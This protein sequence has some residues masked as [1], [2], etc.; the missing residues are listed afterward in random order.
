MCVVR[1]F[2]AIAAV[3]GVLLGSMSPS[4]AADAETVVFDAT[5]YVIQAGR[6]SRFAVFQN[7]LQTALARCGSQ[8]RVFA[9]GAAP[10]GKFDE[11]TRAAIR[12][13]VECTPDNPHLRGG[14]A[15]QGVLTLGVWRAIMGDGPPP[16]V[17]E[18]ARALV[19]SF[20]ATDF[21]DA[22]LWNLCQDGTRAR[23]GPSN[24]NRAA[25]QCFNES[26]P[27]SF[28]TWGPRGATAG[29]GREI[30]HVL[31]M[32]AQ[33]DPQL[34]QRAFGTEY[35]NIDRFI[36]LKGGSA[37]QCDG[38]VPL[39]KFIC[40]IWM[41]PIRRVNWETALAALGHE[42]M[43]RR[44]YDQ[45]YALREFDGAKLER[46]YALWQR[47]GLT[48]SEVDYAYFID[49]IT[50]L[51]GPPD[52][53]GFTE[54]L[55]SCLAGETSAVSVNGAARRCASRLQPHTTQPDL[56]AAR[57]VAFYLDSYP[58]GA[59]TVG[60]I[61]AWASYVPLSATLN[62]ALSD[63][64]PHASQPAADLGSLGA[65]LPDASGTE[66]TDHERTACPPSVLSPDRRR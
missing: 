49:R 28:L 16:T 66:L 3:A 39:K 61:R 42:P 6:H 26:D 53:N 24:R 25:F 9:T 18:R 13:V 62:F 8:H 38:D 45:L 46:F 21:G 30:Q 1:I 54:K 29:S 15:R 48:P 34:L 11:P 51:G 10:D 31:W 59:L 56:R 52:D 60:E 14:A 27:C 44:A 2:A 47:L 19:L 32:A 57:D 37:G 20:E 35:A 33:R 55:T 12:R 41:D 17:E 40:A 4:S 43:I 63:S 58:E 65:A 50:H 23:Y 7:N 22:P 64:A 5:R 36:R